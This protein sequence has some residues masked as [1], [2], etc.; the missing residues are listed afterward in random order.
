MDGA[1]FISVT[2]SQ[3]ST[4]SLLWEIQCKPRCGPNTE[5]IVADENI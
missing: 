4:K 5:V 1:G 2:W 3:C